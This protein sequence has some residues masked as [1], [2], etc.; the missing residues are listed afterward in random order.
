[1]L[2]VPRLTSQERKMFSL[3]VAPAKGPNIKHLESSGSRVRSKFR[4]LRAI[5]LNSLFFPSQL[6]RVANSEGKLKEGV[7]KGTRHVV[8]HIVSRRSD[9]GSLL[10][11][12][13]RIVAVDR[14][15]I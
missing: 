12:R 11:N 1:M 6:I 10:E 7:I 5:E 8:T 15:L 13:S 4:T 9:R 3:T 2:S 14:F